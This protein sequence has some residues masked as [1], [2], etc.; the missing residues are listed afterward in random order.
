M[1]IGRGKDEQLLDGRLSQPPRRCVL[2]E[3]RRSKQAMLGEPN[4]RCANSLKL[5]ELAIGMDSKTLCNS[6]E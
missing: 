3:Y 2:C 4:I 6:W 5:Q 1:N